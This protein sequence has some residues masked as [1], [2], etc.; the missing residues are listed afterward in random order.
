[1]S[2]SAPFGLF[3][4]LSL[5]LYACP[6]AHCQTMVVAYLP[7]WIDLTPYADSIDYANLSH[8]NMAFENPINGSG[9][10]SFDNLNAPIIARAHEHHVKVLVSIGGGSVSENRKQ[11]EQYFSL[12]SDA[13]R[14]AFVSKIADYVDAHQFDGVD[15]DLEGPAV[16]KDFGA[17][18]HDLAA[19][20]KPK[21]KLLTS[22]LSQGYG[23]DQVPSSVFDDLNWV[24]IMAY[25]ATGTWNPKMPG[26]HSSFD[27]AKS[28]VAYWLGR[29][30]PKSKAVLGVPFYGYGFGKAFRN[31]DYAYSEILSTY[32]GAEAADQA[33][34]TIWYNGIG[35][36]KAKAKYV[37]DQGLAGVMIWS[38]DY[39]VKGDKSLL[40]AIHD[41]LTP[42]VPGAVVGK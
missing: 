18:I 2:K 41:A 34:E 32:P 38:L 4:L 39:D 25:D 5:F 13:N 1:M 22:A 40:T 9:E 42:V 8:I 30:L 16:N 12:I 20:L 36:I 29:G 35:T 14:A 28:N 31:H 21:N 26:Q 3:L 15:V 23:G 7:N 37:V 33:G 6:K 24:N 10:M 19:A 27:Y 17:F 11:R